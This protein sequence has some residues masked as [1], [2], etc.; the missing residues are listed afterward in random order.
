MEIALL[1]QKEYILDKLEKNKFV[2]GIF[3]DFTKACDCIV[4]S[5]FRKLDLYGIRGHALALIK[6]YLSHRKQQF[7]LVIFSQELVTS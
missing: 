5:I 1:H 6:S 4:H 7:K 2:L 3:V